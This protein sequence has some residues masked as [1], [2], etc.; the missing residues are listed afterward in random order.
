MLSKIK[1][2]AKYISQKLT[3]TKQIKTFKY[4]KNV[5]KLPV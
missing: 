1:A 3:K 5:F 2:K 4:N